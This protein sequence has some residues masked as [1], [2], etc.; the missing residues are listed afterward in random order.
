MIMRVNRIGQQAFQLTLVCYCVAV[1]RF[2]VAGINLAIV[3]GFVPIQD[4]KM[5]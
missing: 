1:Y 2:T 3:W 4:L 5:I